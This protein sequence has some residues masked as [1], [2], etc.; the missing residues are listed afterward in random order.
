LD[1]FHR[2]TAWPGVTA[3]LTGGTLEPRTGSLVGPM[4]TL[5]ARE[6]LFDLF[7]CSAA[8][9]DAGLGASESSLADAEVKRAVATTSSRIVLAVDHTKLGTRA[10][11]RTFRLDEI[12]VLVTDLDPDDT[13]LDDYRGA[14]L[15]VV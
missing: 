10:Q 7:V 8:A 4:A 5:A 6:L 12:D 3:V 1:T 2:L 14:D 9:V 11:A 13:R 15:E